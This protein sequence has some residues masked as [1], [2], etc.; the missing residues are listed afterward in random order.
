MK[1]FIETL[2][3]DLPEA[4]APDLRSRAPVPPF[5]APPPH[6]PMK[7]SLLAAALAPFG[8]PGSRAEPGDA[9][10]RPPNGN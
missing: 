9:G 3:L 10:R 4:R 7:S 2:G 5:P 8:R 6:F 1:K